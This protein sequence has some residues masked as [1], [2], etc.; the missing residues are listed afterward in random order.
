MHKFQDELTM[1]H[2]SEHCRSIYTLIRSS[3]AKKNCTFL[4]YFFFYRS[5]YVVHLH[6]SRHLLKSLVKLGKL[7]MKFMHKFQDELTM[8]HASEH[9]RSIYTLIRKQSSKKNCTFLAY[10]FFYR[11]FYV[12]HLHFFH[13][14]TL[15]AVKKPSSIKLSCT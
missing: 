14:E 11:S 7:L 5:F 10:F 8:G 9:C 2:A 1:G 12:V 6:S 4:A 13:T 15:N 3:P